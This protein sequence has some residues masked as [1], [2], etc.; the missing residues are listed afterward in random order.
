MGVKRL[1]IWA[2]IHANLVN[3]INRQIGFLP[4]LLDENEEKNNQKIKENIIESKKTNEEQILRAFGSNGGS[5]RRASVPA[6]NYDGKFSKD[7]ENTSLSKND[8]DHYRL[9]DLACR[10]LALAAAMNIFQPQAI[11]KLEASDEGNSPSS[12]KKRRRRGGVLGF[13]EL[14][15]KSKLSAWHF[16]R[17]FKSVTGLTPKT[18]GDKCWEFVK[19][20]KDSGEYTS[21]QA[22]ATSY[23]QTPISSNSSSPNLESPV[24]KQHISPS[25][26]ES[27]QPS[28]QQSLQPPMPQAIQHQPSQ[29]VSPQYSVPQSNFD[30]NMPV[31]DYTQDLSNHSRAFS[32]PDLTFFNMKPNTLFEHAKSHHQPMGGPIGFSK[33]KS[34]HYIAFTSTNYF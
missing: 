24:K 10:H 1:W 7:F 12:G 19:N 8:S 30:F 14:A 16:H 17:V 22:N 15:A 27:H 6:I 2:S 4:P 9:V 32:A 29:L 28:M 3:R 21:F 31:I 26:I 13:K 18:Y 34:Q 25:P 11:Q 23:Y 5:N 33:Y 20:F